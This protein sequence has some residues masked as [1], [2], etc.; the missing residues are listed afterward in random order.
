MNPFGPFYPRELQD[1]INHAERLSELLQRMRASVDDE[2]GAAWLMGRVDEIA[3]FVAC[4][5]QEW[6]LQE[7][8]VSAAAEII[9]AYVDALHPGLKLHFGMTAPSCCTG[10]LNRTVPPPSPLDATL[11]IP[12]RSSSTRRRGPAPSASA[13]VVDMNLRE[14]LGVTQQLGWTGA[15]LR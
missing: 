12:V 10:H 2:A 9:R 8:D 7:L 6:R 11:P 3:V 15:G 14:L 5:A 4:V 13:T 1:A